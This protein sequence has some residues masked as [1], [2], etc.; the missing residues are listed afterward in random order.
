MYIRL[1]V[2][3]NIHML[4]LLFLPKAKWGSTFAFPECDEILETYL[5]STPYSL[6]HVQILL[7]YTGYKLAGG[8]LRKLP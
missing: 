6:S 8:I 3:K 7:L 5:P 2:K 1:L 4:S